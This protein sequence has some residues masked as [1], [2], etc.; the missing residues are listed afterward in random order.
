MSPSKQSVAILAEYVGT[1]T[2]SSTFRPTGRVPRLG[3]GALPAW[4]GYLFPI[5]ADG[6]AVWGRLGLA[7]KRGLDILWGL[8]ESLAVRRWGLPGKRSLD[9]LIRY[10][11]GVTIESG[12]PIVAGHCESR[13]D[14]Q[15][16]AEILGL[17]VRI[18]TPVTVPAAIGVF[19]F[20]K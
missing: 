18:T 19:C 9:T 8:G 4:L 17:A 3:V 13:C 1:H 15:P 7:G 5:S 20:M 14:S 11:E 12:F 2:A 16:K 6:V 10:G